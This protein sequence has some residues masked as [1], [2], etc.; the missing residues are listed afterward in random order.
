MIIDLH[1]HSTASDGGMTPGELVEF[2][3]VRQQVGV[4]ALTDH[5]TVAG[6]AQAREAADRLGA[7]FIAGIE[8]STLWARTNVHIVGLGIDIGNAVLLETM[9]ASRIK[10][11]RRAVDMGRRLA[12]LGMPGMYEAALARSTDK[13]NISRLHFARC[14]VESG[15]VAGVQQAFDKYLGVGRPAYVEAPWGTVAQAVELIRGAGGVAVLAH[16]GRYKFAEPWQADALVEDFVGAGGLAIE[17]VSGS[18]SPV[19]TERCLAWARK[20]DLKVSTGSDFHNIGG[21]RPL[22]GCQGQLTDDM[23]GCV[24]ELLD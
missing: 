24:L 9:A 5:D 15:I 16:P 7:R 2:V 10:R 4:L 11:D 17:A 12:E 20:Y 22:P 8:I 1:M 19:F 21:F 23:P 13:T 6:V 3:V 18:Q 14:M